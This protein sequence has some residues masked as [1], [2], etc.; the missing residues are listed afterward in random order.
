MKVLDTAANL[1][2]RG[3][4]VGKCRLPRAA[5]QVPC[6]RSPFWLVASIA[7]GSDAFYASD[8][9]LR[10]IVKVRLDY[11]EVKETSL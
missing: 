11:R 7:A 1:I 3:S 8:K 5:E 2:V 9:D 10:R 4:R 6:Q